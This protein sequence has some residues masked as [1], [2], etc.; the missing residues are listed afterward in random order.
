MGFNKQGRGQCLFKYALLPPA[1][2]LDAHYHLHL[3]H[4]HLILSFTRFNL[5]TS[6]SIHVRPSRALLLSPLHSHSD[7]ILILPIL[8]SIC[9]FFFPSAHCPFLHRS[10]FY[11]RLLTPP[12]GPF[13]SHA[14]TISF[15]AYG[16]PTSK[17]EVE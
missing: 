2:V 6:P 3:K 11:F 1:V 4:L 12:S 8:L 5:H 14:F 13:L 16:I 7:S 10:L 9:L 15:F 17:I